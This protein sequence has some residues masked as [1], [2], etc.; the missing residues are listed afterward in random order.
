MGEEQCTGE[1][2]LI[3]GQLLF[4]RF[5]CCLTE[6]PHWLFVVRTEQRRSRLLSATMSP[7]RADNN[8]NGRC[9][10][11]LLRPEWRNKSSVQGKCRWGNILHW[12][13]S[14]TT[15][16]VRDASRV[17]AWVAKNCLGNCLKGENNCYLHFLLFL[18]LGFVPF[19][20]LAHI[21]PSSALLAPCPLQLRELGAVQSVELLAGWLSLSTRVGICFTC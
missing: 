14:S 19:L 21:S 10:R 1:V 6:M 13:S 12:R 8:D 16:I 5:F 4:K 9:C 18:L 17:V 7:L 15:A 3:L 20:V 2:D 11:H